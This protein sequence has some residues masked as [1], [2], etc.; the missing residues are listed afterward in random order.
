MTPIIGFESGKDQTL[1][2]LRYPFSVV[3][4]QLPFRCSKAGQVHEF[5]EKI[6]P[7]KGIY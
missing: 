6:T 2:I 5:E 4:F 1:R 7:T 3:K